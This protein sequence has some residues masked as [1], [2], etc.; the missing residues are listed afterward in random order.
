[1]PPTD[2]AGAAP[3]GRRRNRFAAMD[4]YTRLLEP[5]DHAI[6][7]RERLVRALLATFERPLVSNA[8]LL[9]EA[10]TGKTAL[11]QELARQDPGRMYRSVDVPAMIADSANPREDLAPRLKSV[12]DETR[13]FNRIAGRPVVLF[14]DEFH[15]IVQ[16]SPAAVEALKPLLA[17][18]ASHGVRII[19][20]TTLV[21]YHDYVAPNLPLVERLQRINVPPPPRPV[22]IDILMSI[23]EG[24]RAPLSR[25]LAG[26]VYDYAERY[27]PASAQ[28]RKSIMLL[29]SM[30]GWHRLGGAGGGDAVPMDE[31]LL[32]QVL[33]Q[34]ANVSVRIKASP[35]AVKRRI[36]GRVMA[37]QWA[38]EAIDQRLQIC[39][40]GLNDPGRPMASFLFAGSTGVGKTE[41]VKQ[42]TV[43]L[44]GD[45]M[46]HLVRFDMSEYSLDGSVDRFRVALADYV[47]NMPYC[48]I[49]LDEMDK[50]APNVVQLLLQVLDDGRLTDANGRTVTFTNA[51]VVMTT[52]AGVGSGV[53]R[54]M[55]AYAPSDSGAGEQLR[56]WMDTIRQALTGR[57]GEQGG[58]PPEFLGR[59]DTIVPFQ[60]L[61]NATMHAIA[62]KR[63][64]EQRDLLM[65]RHG[66]ALEWTDRVVDYVAEER[67]PGEADVNAGGARYIMSV[68]ESEIM[69]PVARLVNS[70]PECRLVHIDV[71]GTMRV[72]RGSVHRRGDAR[73][74]ARAFDGDGRPIGAP[75]ERPDGGAAPSGPS[76]GAQAGRPRTLR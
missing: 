9:A 8:L 21:E 39:L 17:Q 47:W 4:R 41:V 68:I 37:Q 61:S 58:F 5:A 49:L 69:S 75:D 27:M 6:L 70:C 20:A 15:Q 36:N 48:V 22:V 23:A 2:A 12:F 45:D 71:E 31:A 28:P 38:A 13:E 7:G 1:M 54:N 29:D 67:A 72:D 24:Q 65:A 30:I 19:A 26:T 55:A 52:N 46:R 63:L 10:G 42:M 76:G 44:F 56:D 64:S 14:I 16:L 53:F 74:S 50:A 35:D 51:Y 43:G 34:N 57:P 62:S 66:A 59:I 11:V 73:I 32:A 3:S 33:E 25:E 18:S 60:P 40:A